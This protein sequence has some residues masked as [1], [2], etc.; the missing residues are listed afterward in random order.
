MMRHTFGPRCTCRTAMLLVEQAHGV[1]Q[2]L[3][4]A[5]GGFESQDSCRGGTC[6]PCRQ[7]S[8]EQSKGLQAF[9]IG[10]LS[11]SPVPCPPRPLLPL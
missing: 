8:E 3:V 6:P 11:S 10:A 7:A 2:A 4:G 1:P 5:L 9:L